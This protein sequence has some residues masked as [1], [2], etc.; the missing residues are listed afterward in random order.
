MADERNWTVD[1]KTGRSNSSEQFEAMVNEVESL[2]RGSGFSL[3]NGRVGT[4]AQLIVAQLA[5]VH[6]LV[7]SDQQQAELAKLRHEL[8]LYQQPVQQKVYS[9]GREIMIDTLDVLPGEHVADILLRYVDHLERGNRNLRAV[10]E[11]ARAALERL[12]EPIKFPLDKPSG[13][14]VSQLAATLKDIDIILRDALEGNS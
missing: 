14:L 1:P 2:I 6:G 10:A 8:A 5:H 13:W 7:P 12:E 4:V 11:A 9:L 3:I